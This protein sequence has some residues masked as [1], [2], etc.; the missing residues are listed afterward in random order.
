MSYFT[1]CKTCGERVPIIPSSGGNIVFPHDAEGNVLGEVDNPLACAGG[2]VLV[3]NEA[4]FWS[5]FNWKRA[6]K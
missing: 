2:C 4:V 1:A 6:I 5:P 3:D